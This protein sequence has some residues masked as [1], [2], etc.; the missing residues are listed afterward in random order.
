MPKRNKNS[1]SKSVRSLSDRITTLQNQ[2]RAVPWAGPIGSNPKA[3]ATA[4]SLWTTRSVRVFLQG[5]A[6]ADVTLTSGELLKALGMV[7][8]V[9]D[10]AIK[11]SSIKTWNYTA[12]SDNSNYIRVIAGD[13]IDPGTV[14]VA[15]GYLSGEDVG[16]VNVLPGVKIQ[17]PLQATVIYEKVTTGSTTPVVV[18]RGAP[19][20][21]S[22]NAKVQTYCFDVSL[23][24]QLETQ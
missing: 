4:K 5:A 15:P 10:I 8:T 13:G 1:T 9:E 22:T 3:R 11:V 6:N 18:V 7:S 14:G 16:T 12:A 23:L 24:W 20:S 17:Y 2:S 19:G 21:T